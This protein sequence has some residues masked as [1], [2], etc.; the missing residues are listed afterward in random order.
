MVIRCADVP[1]MWQVVIRMDD[2]DYPSL[3][4]VKKLAGEYLE[5]LDLRR[6]RI[7]HDAISDLPTVATHAVMDVTGIPQSNY[8]AVAPKPSSSEINNLLSSVG[9]SQ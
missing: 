4:I 8:G 1:T 3:N 5:R 6:S 2:M 9:V 7:D